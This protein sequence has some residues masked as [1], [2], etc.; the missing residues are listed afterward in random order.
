MSKK[1]T[2]VFNII[3]FIGIVCYA[4]YRFGFGYDPPF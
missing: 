3:F 2:R 4:I 1:T